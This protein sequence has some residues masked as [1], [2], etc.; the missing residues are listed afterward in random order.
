MIYK[1]ILSS[2]LPLIIVIILFLVF[3]N[4]GIG[5]VR[6]LRSQISQTRQ[7]KTALTEKLNM[8]RTISTT[9]ESASQFAASALPGENTVLPARARIKELAVAN[10]VVLSNLKSDLGASD[11]SG[12]SGVR[13]NF[14]LA[15]TRSE[16]IAFLKLI[17][18]TAPISLVDKITFSESVEGSSATIS[19]KTFWAAFPQTLPAVTKSIT[20]LT[21]EEKNTLDK[22]SA[23][24]QPAS[25]EI[26]TDSEAGGESIGRQN[27]FLP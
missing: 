22:I 12:L 19:V 24:A 9:V 26:P 27:P 23:F 20:D 18:N 14:D 25:T 3:G 16:I 1:R 10:G 5:R 21:V 11:V 13:L 2:T 4:Y 6:N 15:G 7:D 17:E 8:L